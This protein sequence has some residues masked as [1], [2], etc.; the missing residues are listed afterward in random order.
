MPSSES[1]RLLAAVSP[2]SVRVASVSV[3]LANGV[4]YLY[5]SLKSKHSLPF[6]CQGFKVLFALDGLSPGL[7]KLIGFVR[8][9]FCP[10][11]LY[12]LHALGGR[13]RRSRQIGS[14]E[15]PFAS[16]ETSA[17]HSLHAPS[18]VIFLHF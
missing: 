17:L 16:L 18:R 1:R 5:K 7:V 10:L 12:S 2:C 14:V 3:R 4:L 15:A 8:F 9:S 11:L 13:R 6:F